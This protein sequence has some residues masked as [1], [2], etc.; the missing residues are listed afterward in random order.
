LI[1]SYIGFVLIWYCWRR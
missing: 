1:N